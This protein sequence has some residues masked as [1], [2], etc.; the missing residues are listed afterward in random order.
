MSILQLRICRLSG[1]I[2]A[3][4][5]IRAHIRYSLTLRRSVTW[6]HPKRGL[7]VRSSQNGTLE[8][9]K[10]D[11][12]L[13]VMSNVITFEGRLWVSDGCWQRR[14]VQKLAQYM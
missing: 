12:Q 7:L 9:F 4:A 3:R 8:M 2:L 11:L 14:P 13:S 10:P 1:W 6:P 5:R